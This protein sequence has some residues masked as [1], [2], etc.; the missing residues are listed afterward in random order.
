VIP[1]LL[2]LWAAKQSTAAGEDQDATAP[3]LA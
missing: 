3:R 1:I 2:V